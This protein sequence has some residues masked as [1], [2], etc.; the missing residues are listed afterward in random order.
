MNLAKLRY[1]FDAARLGSVTE[2][3]RANFVTQS[4]ISQAIRG[5]ESELGSALIHHR[6]NS[7]ELTEAGQV[8]LKECD[9]IF[10]SVENLKASLSRVGSELRGTLRIAATN[11]IALTLLAPAMSAIAKKNPHLKLRLKLGNSDQVK[12]YLRTQEAELGFILEDDEMDGFKS[13]HVKTG[14]FVLIGNRKNASLAKIE[15]LIITREAK[16]EIKQLAQTLGDEFRVRMEVFSW[17][18]IRQ[19]CLEGAG[20]GYLPD[21]LL[22]E[23]L[24]KRRLIRV[25]KNLKTWEYKLVAIQMEKRVLT[26]S[27]K[28][29][30]KEVSSSN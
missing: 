23:D 30:L 19:L 26:S 16:V 20:I 11:S 15:N 25:K 28:A 3:A 5:L 8:A 10:G 12:D 21:Y 27:A 9:L 4:A 29:F 14:N 1:F 18:L 7:F 22:E 13:F 24:K 6:K 17:E 2:A